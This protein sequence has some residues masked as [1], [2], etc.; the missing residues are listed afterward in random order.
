MG[1]IHL[2]EKDHCCIR[3]CSDRTLSA[4]NDKESN[5]V[6]TMSDKPRAQ[7]ALELLQ[8]LNPDMKGSYQHVPS[9]TKVNY[10]DLFAPYSNLIVICAD[11]E[12]YC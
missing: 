9:L 1:N 3:T 11:L 5:F 8:E 12:P 2:R 4:S 7:V 10:S 6:V